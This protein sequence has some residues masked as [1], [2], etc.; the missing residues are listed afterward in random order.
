VRFFL[1]LSREG[2]TQVKLKLFAFL[3]GILCSL[4]VAAQTPATPLVTLPVDESKLV[5]LR[6]TVHP[7]AQ[8]R[9]DRGAV[10]P[11]TPAE[12]LL[13]VL[14]RPPEREA[15]FQQLL[16]DLHTPSSPSYH[17]WLTAD[18]IGAQFGPAGSDMAAR[19]RLQREPRLACP[20]IHRILRHRGPSQLRL[21][22]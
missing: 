9:Y 17:H 8:A 13:L 3:L 12:R 20:A 4:S 15:A 1:G 6:G 16:I 10:N 21:S 22:H 18:Q 5:T 11:S 14:N 19:L 7:L 2:R